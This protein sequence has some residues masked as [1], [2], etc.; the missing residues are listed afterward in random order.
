LIHLFLRVSLS[1][2]EQFRYHT[3]HHTHY[4]FNY[5]QFFIFCDWFWGTLK[6]NTQRP[7]SSEKGARATMLAA[8]ST[9]STKA[10]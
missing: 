10:A 7:S 1:F 5:G 9:K 8:A 3:I 2:L 6:E 4:H